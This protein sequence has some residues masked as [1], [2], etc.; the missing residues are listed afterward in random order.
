MWRRGLK[1]FREIWMV[2]W[3]PAFEPNFFIVMHIALDLKSPWIRSGDVRGCK[4]NDKSN[5]KAFILTVVCESNTSFQDLAGTNRALAGTKHVWACCIFS[6]RT[7][8][9]WSGGRIAASS[10]EFTNSKVEIFRMEATCEQRM[11]L[12]EKLRN[13]DVSE[14]A[15]NFFLPEIH[16]ELR[17]CEFDHHHQFWCE[18]DG[19]L[20]GD[21][22]SDFWIGFNW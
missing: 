15:M 16:S 20:R 14:S 19:H 2:H 18:F 6:S 1:K 5:A 3:L 11:D 8:V 13:W 22:D 9:S 10:S 21:L 4:L 17:H 7:P 12:F